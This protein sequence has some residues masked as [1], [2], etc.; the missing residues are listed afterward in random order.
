MSVMLKESIKE[1]HLCPR[2]GQ[3]AD[4]HKH[5]RNSN[6]VIAE[7]DAIKVL[8]TQTVCSNQTVEC[9]NLVHLNSGNE[10]AATLTDDIGD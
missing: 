9:K 6:L 8:H 2:N 1:A 5:T 4:R 3:E 10:G 7:F